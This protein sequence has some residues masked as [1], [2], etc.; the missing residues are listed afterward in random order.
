MRNTLIFALIL[1]LLFGCATAAADTDAQWKAQQTAGQGYYV[2]GLTQDE[3]DAL[4]QTT[5]IKDP[6]SITG[7]TVTFRHY[8]PQADRVRIRGEWS[9][10]Q[11]VRNSLFLSGSYDPQ[12]WENGMFPLQANMSDWPAYDMAKNEETGVWYYTIP[13]P[14]GTWSY[15]FYE[16]GVEGAELTD[17]TDAVATTDINNRPWEK[18]LGEQGNSQVRVPFDSEKQTVD[19]S[20]QL[21]RTDGMVGTTEI[22]TYTADGVAEKKD[23]PALAVYLPYGYDAQREQPYKTLYISHGGGLESETSWY[24]KGSLANITDNLMAQGVVEPMVVVIIN[25]YAVNFDVDS[26][27]A[28]VL[29]L[30]ENN[31]NVS[32]NV[33][34]RAVCGLSRGG[35]FTTDIMMTYPEAFG[36]YGVFSGAGFT[37]TP[38]DEIVY[39]EAVGQAAV[40]TAVGYFDQAFVDVN[41]VMTALDA[42]GFEYDSFYTY[43]GHDWNTWRQIYVDFLTNFLWK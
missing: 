8:A 4:T 6:D 12:Q 26:F 1:A 39:P 41:K 7:Y 30:V 18:E 15:R 24:N 40:Y 29:P 5:I 16:G 23:D 42:Q 10:Y 13:L 36:V 2:E 31:Y 19:F 35:M 21:P 33:E 3:I 22:L 9:L 14:C 27:M 32:S 25:N 17:Y 43:G 34:D 11:T 20:V 38:Q 28:D 37:D